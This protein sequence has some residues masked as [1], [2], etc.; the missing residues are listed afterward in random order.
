MNASLKPPTREQFHAYDALYAYFNGALFDDKLPP[1]LLNFSRQA[2][3]RGFFAAERWSKGRSVRH[4]ISLNPE[5][6]RER[7]PKD[8]ASTLVHEM[9]HLW[10]HTAGKP[11]RN[12]YH[13]EQWATKMEAVGLQPSSTGEPGGKRVGQRMTHFVIAGGAFEVAFDDMPREFILPWLCV[14][15]PTKA[16]KA[17]AKSKVKYTCPGCEL[18]VWGKPGLAI[19]CQEC[20]GLVVGR[21]GGLNAHGDAMFVLAGDGDEGGGDAT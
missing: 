12:G 11:S 5:T 20:S 13:N 19:V 21:R 4:E 7:T 18:N 3:T 2:N 16:A 9:V 8:V 6:L 17:S 10:Q 1:V 15:E 14:R